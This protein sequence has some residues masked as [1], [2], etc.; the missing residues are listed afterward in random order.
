MEK[1]LLVT[2]K[3]KTEKDEWP[4]EE[5]A[6][7]LEE[8]AAACGV[9]AV[10]NIRSICE[11]PTSNF[12]IGSG[13]AKELALTAQELDVDVLIFSQDLSGTQQ[14]NLEEITGKKIIDRTQL[15][16]DIFAR[17]AKTPEGKMQV[18]LAQ[19]QYLIPRLSGKGV[20]LSRLGGGVGTRGPGEQKL[21][22][23]RRKIRGKIDTLK[24]D[25]KILTERR[26]VMRK[27]RIDNLIPLVALV[28]YTSAGKSTLLNALTGADQNVSS[29]LFTTLD[30]LAKSLQLDNGE[31]IVL[32]DTVGFLHNLPHHLIEAFQAT[33]EEV[34]QADLLIHVLDVANANV[35]EQNKAVF[36]VLKKLGVE[37]KPVIT[38]LNKID[39]MND[40]LW[41]EKMQRDFNNA[42][43]ISAK[44]KQNLDD[45]LEKIQVVFSERMALV[46]IIIPHQRMDL[47]DFIYRQG[48][49]KE[50]KYLQNSVEIVASI[51]KVDSKKLMHNKD[52]EVIC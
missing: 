31:R 24:A 50:V 47:L 52:I 15:I 43:V 1:A 17:H 9:E 23:D 39:L 6:L 22:M 29:G 19:L 49:V 45:L 41:L 46:K 27:R 12:L 40:K 28:G 20:M 36:E 5:S 37:G 4:I 33:L 25:L 35:Y 42:I 13:K 8:L 51:S 11:K 16:L 7:E 26:I 21:E 32:S 38:A 48:K 2:V 34:V 14:R 44:F 18:E 10:D 3:L 30:P